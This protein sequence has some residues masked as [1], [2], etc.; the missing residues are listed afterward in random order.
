ML[1]NMLHRGLDR[2][3]NGI[4]PQINEINSCH[5]DH[6]APV[7]DNACVQNMVKDVEK[8][9][10]VLT[11]LGACENCVGLGLVRHHSQSLRYYASIGM[12]F[13]SEYQSTSDSDLGLPTKSDLHRCA[14]RLR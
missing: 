7:Q 4:Q 3:E 5:G 9:G 14:L 2:S 13:L 11:G 6:E 8:R 1:L 10:F 12:D